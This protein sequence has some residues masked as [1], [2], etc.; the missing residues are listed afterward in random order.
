MNTTD[1]IADYLTRVRNA[2]RA[3]HKRVD[4]PL[5]NLKR[6]LTK[7]LAAQKYVA[8]FTE[9][10]DG[11]QGILRISLRYT[12]GISAITGLSR[13]SR[14]GLRVYSPAKELPRVLNGLGLAVISTSRGLM[15]DKEAKYQKLGGE[16]L[17]QV[18]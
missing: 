14:P 13:V 16:I 6:D 4:V 2:I 3:K 1:P 8:S 9:I 10:K 11:R 5:S 7:I 15:T 17:C 12:D 18:W